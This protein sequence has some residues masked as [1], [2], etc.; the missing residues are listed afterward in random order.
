MEDVKRHRRRLTCTFSSESPPR[1]FTTPAGGGRATRCLSSLP[2]SS[3]WLGCWFYLPGNSSRP[4]SLDFI[5]LKTTWAAVLLSQS[6]LR[7]AGGV[8]GISQALLR[9]LLLQRAAVGAASAAYLLGLSHPAH[10]LQVRVHG[11]GEETTNK[12]I[13]EPGRK[14][15][16]VELLGLAFISTGGAWRAQR[17][18]ERGRRGARGRRGGVQLGAP[19][20][21]SQLQADV[22]G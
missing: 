17:R 19:K 7:D 5:P 11:Q 13:R 14:W 10:G 2:S 3:S 16:F 8:S 12:E 20:G 6:S 15:G 4:S 9:L 1:C 22:A 21:H 18:G